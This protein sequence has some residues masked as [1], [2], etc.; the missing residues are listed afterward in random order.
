MA[1]SKYINVSIKNDSLF[2]KGISQ[3]E[4][5][6]IWIPYFDLNRDY[7][8]IKNAIKKL[9][10]ILKIAA[11]YA[12][13]IHILNQDPWEVLCS[14]IISQ[15][16]NIPRIKGIIKRLCETF[17]DIISPAQYS[18]PNANRLACLNEGDFAP[19][20]CG[21][22]WK[23]ILDAAQK[24]A[25]KEIILD[26]LKDLSIK[27]ARKSLTKILGVGPKVAECTLLY[28]LHKLEAF[29]VDTWIRK[30]MHTFFPGRNP[31]FFGEYA[32]IAQQYIFHYCRNN[33]NL[34]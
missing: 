25:N 32:G 30:A 34:F 9:H 5:K 4:F 24:I 1:F 12:P 33:P 21:F 29:P 6:N 15:N 17:G 28:G 31:E 26:E 18:F 19:L 7:L 8:A 22:R 20:R 14:F 3:N 2:I 27:T 10:P 16:N 11:E 13:G 23:Y